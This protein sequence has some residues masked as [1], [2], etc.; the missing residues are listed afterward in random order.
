MNTGAILM[1]CTLCKDL[2]YVTE[3]GG[4]TALA[5]VCDCRNPCPAC[6]G[7][8]IVIDPSTL[9][10]KA[11][12]CECRHLTRR[13]G[14]FNKAGLPA[15]MHS[16]TLDLFEERTPSQGRVKFFV[17]RF[18]EDYVPGNRGFLL[19]GKPGTGKTHIVCAMARYFVLEKGYSV[20]FVDF[21]QLL[22]DL[23][24]GFGDGRSESD[25]ISPLVSPDVLI[26]DELGKGRA[27]DWEVS[28]LDQLVSRRYNAGRTVI[29]TSNFDPN[30]GAGQDGLPGLITR[31]DERIHS[32]LCEICEFIEIQGDDYRKL[33][34]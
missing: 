20:R 17:R 32:R 8:G 34:R 10:R 2:G 24:A 30:K 25:L 27:T 7:S 33:G 5:R 26:I 31:I 13:V 22:S 23:K 28:I 14:L 18:T 6:G 4:E 12:P 29:A 1:N 9:P 11:T 16:K 21:F 3:P 15:R 19:W